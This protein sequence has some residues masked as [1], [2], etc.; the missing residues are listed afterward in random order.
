MQCNGV[1]DGSG[2][3]QRL[4]EIRDVYEYFWSFVE[5]VV[6]ADSWWH[7]GHRLGPLPLLGGG[8]VCILL[9]ILELCSI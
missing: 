7:S 6:D 9:C 1:W 3:N 4:G 5:R 2:V 8:V